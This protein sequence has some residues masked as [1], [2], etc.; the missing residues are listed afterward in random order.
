[1]DV[2]RIGDLLIPLKK[3]VCIKVDAEADGERYTLVLP[4]REVGLTVEQTVDFNKYIPF[5]NVVNLNP[6]RGA[7]EA[8]LAQVIKHPENVKRVKTGE[9][10]LSKIMKEKK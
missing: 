4:D 3:I 9:P 1:M 10:D 7:Y 2:I 5:S 6:D 8:M